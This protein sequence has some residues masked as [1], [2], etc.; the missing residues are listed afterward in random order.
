MSEISAG[1]FS[2][3]LSNGSHF[4]FRDFDETA[5]WLDDEAAAFKWLAEG[6]VKAGIQGLRDEYLSE[7]QNLKALLRNWRKQPDEKQQMQQFEAAFRRF[8]SK[9]NVVRSDHEFARVASEISVP[10]GAVAAAAA[11]GFLLGVP[12]S[13]DVTTI[14]GIFS[15]LMKRHGID[16]KSPNLVEG[17]IRNL[18]STAMQD[19]ATQEKVWNELSAK[20]R[21][22]IEQAKGSF[23][24]QTSQFRQ[25][26][27]D[28]VSGIQDSANRA[29]KDI[30]DTESAY[31]EQMRL[32]A[33]VD[34]WETK[35]AKHKDAIY[36]SRL[37]L[38]VFAVLGSIGLLC[39]LIFLAAKAAELANRT[40]IPDAAIYLKFAAIGA[41]LATIIF[42]A[43]RVLLRIY[44][45]DR[46]LLTDAE[47]RVAMI[48]TY[49]ALS[50]EGKV[51]GADR[52]LILAPVFRSAADGI[53]KEEGP[54][55]SVVGL[56]AKA[57]DV[58]AVR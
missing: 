18:V 8:Y 46:H 10:D 11:F 17:T 36:R 43:G 4:S 57:L 39:A 14:K 26:A 9:K 53:V 41:I 54:D 35:A 25:N 56:L 3:D 24:E 5:Q 42:W 30:R 58:R 13:I 19:R 20:G 7:F 15:A 48:K 55:V 31:R 22:L 29:I 28:L 1:Y 33:P 34:Y 32:Q 2:I 21:D 51:D 47:E 23:E 45:S 49:L 16:P 44:L 6:G 27:G 38:I 40:T 50:H 37:T 52:A 12:C